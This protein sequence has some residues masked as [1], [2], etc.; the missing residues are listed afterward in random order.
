METPKP[1]ISQPVS[2]TYI[3]LP[4]A[5]QPQLVPVPPKPRSKIWVWVLA[6]VSLLGMGIVAGVFLGKQLYSK[7]ILQSTPSPVVEITSTPDS[8]ANWKE[9]RNSNLGFS[10]SYPETLVKLERKD[11]GNISPHTFIPT[12]DSE[13]TQVCLYYADQ[14]YANSDFDG[15]DISINIDTQADTVK[16]C[17]DLKKDALDNQGTKQIGGVNFSTGTSGN[18]AGGHQIENHFLKT[19]YNGRCFEIVQ[20]I[21]T[22]SKSDNSPPGTVNS[23]LEKDKAQVLNLL[24]QILSTFKFLDQTI[25]TSNWKVYPDN[26]AAGLPYSFKY[27]A[28]VEVTGA[29]DIIYLK[30]GNSTLYHRYAGKTT[31]LNSLMNNYQVFGAP[32]IK[33]SNRNPVTFGNLSGYEAITPDGLSKYYFLGSNSLNGFLVFNYDMNDTKASDLFSQ[34]LSTVKFLK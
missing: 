21:V 20:S 31:E 4:V 15:A 19:F 3:P 1:T 18:G 27:P 22:S 13:T 23:F 30:T 34:I 33:F 16:K 14:S 26:A 28:E 5:P 32:A 25:D 17:T 9:Y 8:T 6:G 10:I 29:Q 11:K 2:S 7:P 12:C 24:D